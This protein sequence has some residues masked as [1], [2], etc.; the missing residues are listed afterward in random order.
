[1]IARHSPSEDFETG[2]PSSP[3]EK[4]TPR[5]DLKRSAGHSL[6]SGFKRRSAELRQFR[7]Y[8]ASTQRNFSAT[9]TGWRREQNSNSQYSF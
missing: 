7:E 9:K 2:L 6:W 5:W 4:S 8:F 1:M 3:P